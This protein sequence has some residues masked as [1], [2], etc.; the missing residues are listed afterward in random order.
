VLDEDEF[1]KTLIPEL[2]KHN[3]YASFV[4]QLNM[5]GFHKRVGLSDNSMKASERKNKTPSEYYNPY[6]KRGHPN[7]LWL[8]NKPKGGTGQKKTKGTTRVKA[9]DGADGESDDDR[10]DGVEETYGPGYGQNNIQGGQRQI[11]AAPESGPLQRREMAL[12]Q[13]QLQEIQKQQGAISNAISRLRKDHNQLYQQAVAFQTLHDRHESSINAIL[14]FLATVYNR[15]LEGQSGPN[16]AQMFA[17]AIPQD[18]QHQGSVVDMGDLGNQQQHNPGNLSP[19][20]KPQRLLMAPPAPVTPASSVQTPMCQG[21]YHSAT[22]PRHGAIEELFENSPA[23]S[24]QVKSEIDPFPQQ[25]MMNIINNTN[26][27]VS[28]PGAKIMNFPDVLS[29][30]EHSNGN[31]PLTSQERNDMLHLIA[32]TASTPGSNNALVSPTPPPQPTLEQMHYTQS[33]LDELVR[34]Q[35]EQ[36]AK[37]SEVAGL[38]QPL[39]PSGSIPGL[40]DNYFQD[41]NQSP[42]A[43]GNL[44]LDQYLD[45]GAYYTNGDNSDFNYDGL[46]FG[47]GDPSNFD[48]SLDGA[49]DGGADAGRAV[50]SRASSESRDNLEV[51]EDMQGVGQRSPS[52]R[53]RKG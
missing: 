7:L 8:I 18:Q 10:Q 35:Q 47:G 5:Y 22:T 6:F 32:G 13:N 9:E 40:T 3:N 41:T 49:N 37:L 36:E 39:S 2:F 27:Q 45:T 25:N 44:D 20:R 53:R 12:V 23:E 42:S 46:N 4:R 34:M 43:G 14:T 16:I 30:F 31:S 17:N 29:H 19:Q 1:A 50:E 21:Q 48:F 24:P 33:E 51:T 52:K 11:S 28:R 15:S 38:I 26:A